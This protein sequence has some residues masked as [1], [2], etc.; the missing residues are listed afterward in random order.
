M[1]GAGWWWETEVRRL[2]AAG[3]GRTPSLAEDRPAKSALIVSPLFPAEQL[4]DKEKFGLI[5]SLGC[6]LE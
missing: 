3:F 2:G 5:T 6:L 1:K 4:K